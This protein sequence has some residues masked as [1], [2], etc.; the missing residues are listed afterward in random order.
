M[1]STSRDRASRNTVRRADQVFPTNSIHT[2][3]SPAA[4]RDSISGAAYPNFVPATS[5]NGTAATE[6]GV[7]HALFEQLQD[8]SRRRQDDHD[9]SAA[10]EHELRE[11]EERAVLSAAEQLERASRR[12]AEEAERKQVSAFLNRQRL[13]DAGAASAKGAFA[14]QRALEALATAHQAKRRPP[15]VLPKL[16]IVSKR[17]RTNAAPPSAKPSL[18][19]VSDRR[20]LQDAPPVGNAQARGENLR[21]EKD[22]LTQTSLVDGYLD[23]SSSDESDRGNG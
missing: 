7:T 4:D 9:D 10:D 8:A 15:P 23:V 3:A 14:P 16:R 22:T 21:R 2:T 6:S 11:I 13:I 18:P 20:P 19:N 5:T 1:A 12:A 17:Q